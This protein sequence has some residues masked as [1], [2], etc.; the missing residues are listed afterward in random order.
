MP[1]FT[2]DWFS[3][4]LQNFEHIKANLGSIDSI[5]EIGCHEGRSTCWMIENMLSSTG[6]ITCIDPYLDHDPDAMSIFGLPSKTNDEL[7]REN[8]FRSNVQEVIKPSQKIEINVERSCA[9]LPHLITQNQQYDFIYV[10]GNHNSDACLSD[11]V[12]CFSLLRVGG[13]MLFDDYLW[14]D[15]DD[16]MLRCKASIDAF[17]NLYRR[18]L[19]FML[20]NYQLAVQKK[21]P[22]SFKVKQERFINQTNPSIITL[23][24]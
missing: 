22:V 19:D 1:T 6:T 18:Q 14:E 21:A 16:H 7:A 24:I 20:I 12:M 9:A 23:N 8:L 3:K 13:I 15:V 5:L 11:A 17:T 4:N 10:D 2:G